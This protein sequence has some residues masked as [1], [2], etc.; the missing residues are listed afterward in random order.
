[1]PSKKP[2]DTRGTNTGGTDDTVDDHLFWELAESHIAAGSLVEGQLMRSR[3]LRTPTGDFV[4][5]ADYRSGDLIVKLTADRVSALIDAGT[6]TSFAPAG[7]TFREWVQV[8][9]RDE[10]QWQSLMVEAVAVAMGPQR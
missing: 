7:K 6:G 5:M 3:C 9:G 2:T 8:G 10:R 4:A 1:M